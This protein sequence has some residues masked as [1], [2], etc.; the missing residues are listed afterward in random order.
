VGFERIGALIDSRIGPS[1][2]PASRLVGDQTGRDRVHRDA[3]GSQLRRE[4]HRQSHQG[5]LADS[6]DPGGLEGARRDHVHDRPPPRAAIAGTCGLR[7]QQPVR[8][9]LPRDSLPPLQR[10]VSKGLKGISAI[11]AALLI[12]MS[13]PPSVPWYRHDRP[14][15]VRVG[16]RPGRR[17]WPRRHRPQW[18]RHLGWRFVVEVCQHYRGALLGEARGRTQRQY[19]LRRQ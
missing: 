3:F 10:K 15:R 13:S 2:A 1:G 8:S 7:A 17:R 6:V 9:G 12:R 11:K 18:H 5:V 16:H 14:G 4:V 19:R